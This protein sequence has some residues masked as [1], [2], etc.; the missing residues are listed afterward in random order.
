MDQHR[1]FERLAANHAAVTGVSDTYVCPLCLG[2]TFT[3]VRD[4]ELTWDH[5]PPESIGGRLQVPVCSHCNW[6]A[7]ATIEADLS[8]YARRLDFAAVYGTA[9]PVV[10]KFPGTGVSHRN[11][12]KSQEG[13]IML[14]GREEANAPEATREAES[15]LTKALQQGTGFT[16]R[17]DASLMWRPTYLE[18]AFLKAAY[19]FLFLR[20]GYSA[21][22]SVPF[23]LVR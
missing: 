1:I 23:E 11:A 16:I 20:R 17:D 12:L 9:A 19:L 2:S 5:V 10:L 14:V 22:L 18:C 8:R 21:I 3:S 4:A 7:G 6:A 13:A 15:A